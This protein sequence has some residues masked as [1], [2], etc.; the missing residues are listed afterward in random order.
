MRLYVLNKT[1]KFGLSAATGLD[2]RA[3]IVKNGVFR[4]F[5]P[6]FLYHNGFPTPKFVGAFTALCVEGILKIKKKITFLSKYFLY[7]VN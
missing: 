2:R 7:M 3:K 1:P 6:I 4:E 5:R